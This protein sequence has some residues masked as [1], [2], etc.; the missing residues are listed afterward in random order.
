MIAE[1]EVRFML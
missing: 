1:W